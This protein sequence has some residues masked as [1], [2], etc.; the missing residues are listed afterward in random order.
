M[1]TETRIWM[2]RPAGDWAEGLPVGNGR[3]AAMVLGAVK[4]ER[5][6]LNHEWL[7]RGTGRKRDVE[8]V[9]HRLPEVRA[10]LLAG[11]YTEGTRLANDAF[12]G[13]GGMHPEGKP[14]RVDPYQTAGDLY[15]EIP[16]GPHWDY[17]RELDL[18]TGVAQVS[19]QAAPYR[20]PA[21]R[22]TRTTV[23]HLTRDLLLT[24]VVAAGREFS[25]AVSLDRLFSPDCAVTREAQGDTLTLR[26]RIAVGG[27]GFVVRARVFLAGGSV[28]PV[29]S[30]KLGFV[31]AKA[32]L[33]AINI[34]V[35][36]FGRDADAEAAVPDLAL[37]DWDALL[38]ENTEAFRQALGGATLALGFPACDLSTD[39]RLERVRAGTPDPALPELW[40]NYGRYLL[41]SSSARGTLPANLQGKWCDDLYPPWDSDLHQDINMEM[42]YWIA[43]PTGLPGSMEALFQHLERCVPHGREAARQLYGCRGIWLPIQTDPWGRC[44]PESWGWAVWV[45]AA[46]W[47]AQ[48]F[49]THYEFTLDEAFLRDRAYPFIKEA[50]A[51]YEDYLIEDADGV[52][53]IVPSQSPE[54][55]FE[56]VDPRFPVAIC[57]SATSDVMLAWDCLT[58]A[59][60]AAETLGVDTDKQRHWRT[61]LAKLPPL[62]IG[63]DGRLREWNQEFKEREP[64]HRHISHL[65]GFFPGEQVTREGTP[66][67]F[68]A[69]RESL[70]ARLAAQDAHAA[71][72]DTGWCLS[73]YA[74]CYAHYGDGDRALAILHKLASKYTTTSLL[75]LHPPRFFQ[76][77]GNFGGAMAVVEMLLQSQGEVLRFLPALP[78]AWPSGRVTGLRARGGF[79]VDLTWEGGKLKEAVVRAGRERTCRVWDPD[80][81]LAVSA[82]TGS[83]VEV[84]RQGGC[85]LFDLGRGQ[86]VTV[87]RPHDPGN[88]RVTVAGFVGTADGASCRA[89]ER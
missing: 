67:L 64:G 83:S 14:V 23:A 76:I 50:A 5:L 82:A 54:N 21:A 10:K 75:D 44:T 69:A 11:D 86:T 84:H 42:N 31:N 38:R 65:I 73:W 4:R 46:A 37:A 13:G 22:L 27:V 29:D 34:G 60:K 28:R 49:W 51:F 3:L 7:W 36:V 8:A 63:S 19:F 1:T 47:L 70:D 68:E 18:E 62:Q 77:D 9:A 30:A 88:P 2:D 35:D 66:E 41:F 80:R 61:M 48:H 45:G 57:V 16:H 56:G 79:T 72:W 33:V 39:R 6:A 81:S 12:G 58:H 26:G 89:P 85:L 25:G 55:T 17:R 20:W 24:H 87:F 59:A 74:C 78:S 32:V 52:L 53:Q 43:E 71:G 15:I 40:F